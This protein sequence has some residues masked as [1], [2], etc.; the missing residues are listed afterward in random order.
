MRETSETLQAIFAASPV[1]IMALDRQGN[2]IKWRPAAER[3]FGG[4]EQEVIGRFNPI[5]PE[6][7]VDEF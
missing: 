1:A 7:K 5:V 2:V 3:T 6:D 4:S